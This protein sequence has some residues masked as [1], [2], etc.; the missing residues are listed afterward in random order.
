MT[1]TLIIY[2]TTYSTFKA[3][4][5]VYILRSSIVYHHF[6]LDSKMLVIPIK[7]LSICCL[8]MNVYKNIYINEN[9]FVILFAN[10]NLF[11]EFSTKFIRLVHNHCC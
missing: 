2:H 4:A 5:F 6:V 7:Q 1:F 10:N 3:S 8:N 11:Y 9:K